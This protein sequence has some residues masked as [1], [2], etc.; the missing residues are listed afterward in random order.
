[1]NSSTLLAGNTHKSMTN[2]AK[3]KFG[4]RIYLLLSITDGKSE[5]VARVLWDMPGV[6]I[7]ERLEGDPSLLVMVEAQNRLTLAELLMPVIDKVNRVTEDL[8]L[9]VAQ[10]HSGYTAKPT[11]Q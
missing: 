10:A 7:V 8:R 2:S 9:L 6:A 11:P 5:Q 3:V 1:M 4:E